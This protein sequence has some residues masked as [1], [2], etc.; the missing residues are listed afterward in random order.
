MK[1]VYFITAS[2]HGRGGHYYSLFETACKVSEHE[3]VLILSIGI[4][5]SPVLDT[6]PGRYIHIDYTGLF[7]TLRKVI[8]LIRKERPDVL[9]GFDT[10]SFFYARLI[11]ILNKVPAVL[12]RC[13]GPNPKNFPIN[14]EIIVYSIE[15]F[16]FLKSLKKFRSSNL[17]LIS[18]RV[19][20][21]R[22]DYK[23]ISEI[24]NELRLSSPTVLRI[25]RITSAYKKS[26]LQS[27][28]L[29]HMLNEKGIQAKL[30]VIG[31][32]QEQDVFEELI[33]YKSDKIHFLTKDEFTVNASRLIDVAD[34]VVGTG[35]G[36]M[37]AA[38][39][40]KTMLA[41][42]ANT[43]IPLLVNKNNVLDVFKV[44]FSPRFYEDR[45]ETAMFSEILNACELIGGEN[46]NSLTEF[47]NEN[48]SSEKIYDKH[49]QIYK[50]ARPAKFKVF[51][52]IYA[53]LIITRPRDFLRRMFGRG[54]LFLAM[55]FL[56]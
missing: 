43:S 52:L 37:E 47:A 9:H 7:S 46:V 26:I 36:F 1:I 44:N 50:R 16:N 45:S 20:I 23:K 22:Q 42:T 33:Q 29:T 38:I 6:F 28:K 3:E 32:I 55:R 12:T 13:G 10:H 25:A 53:A 41:P 48:F 18:N 39:L 11:S 54:K 49:I 30:V 35:R 56:K 5:S 17:S 34:F 27:I 24:K 15:N 51:E 40:N 4:N 14:K 21:E 2:R 31:A 19:S 8:S